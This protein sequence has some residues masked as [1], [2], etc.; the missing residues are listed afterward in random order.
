MQKKINF[1][2]PKITIKRMKKEIPYN[3][4][5]WRT[6][7]PLGGRFLYDVVMRLKHRKQQLISDWTFSAIEKNGNTIGKIDRYDQ[8]TKKNKISLINEGYIPAVKLY[9]TMS[10][11]LVP[12]FIRFHGG[13]IFDIHVRDK[14]GEFIYSQDTPVTLNDDMES[15]AT[16]RFIKQLGKTAL[17]H[18]SM[19]QIAFFGILA[20]GVVLGL[21]MMGFFN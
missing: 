1:K 10:M 4:E 5:Y 15:T 13:Q 20:A 9:D 19:Q 7:G 2:L 18:Q 12:I 16:E 17:P 14:N 6:D 8:W 3:H 11:W 21:F